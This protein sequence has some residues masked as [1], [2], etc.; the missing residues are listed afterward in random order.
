MSAIGKANGV[1]GPAVAMLPRAVDKRILI[2]EDNVFVARQCENALS[3][4][5]YKVLEIVSRAE[6]AITVALQRHPQLILMDIYLPG[7]RDGVDAAIE[8][9]ERCGIRSIFASELDS[10]G[11][12]RAAAAR[13]LGWLAKPF[14][15]TKLM[16]AVKSA[17]QAIDAGS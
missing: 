10:A 6:D 3:E 17:I 12:A 5:G 4:A 14:N 15:K 1:P 13:P 16:T 2:V 7:K 9:F 11:R 8:I